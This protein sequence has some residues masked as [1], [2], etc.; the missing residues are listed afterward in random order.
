MQRIITGVNSHRKI[1]EILQSIGSKKFMLVCDGAFDF[2]PIKDYFAG[3][4]MPHIKFSD[5]SVNPLYE[6]VV[7][8]VELL[9]SSDCDAIVAVGGG[10]SIDVAKCIKL[11]AKM[12]PGENY[13][14]Q[15]FFDSEIP[16]I[17]LPTT[18]GTGSESTRYAVIYYGEQKQSVTHD[19]IVPNYAILDSAVLK[20]L[21]LYQRKCTLLD[22][23][24]QGIESWWSVNSTEESFG[25]SEMAVKTIIKNYL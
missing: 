4:F 2:L 7:K 11:F 22:A 9:R 1:G 12:T 17:A 13:L 14:K 5:F 19:S 21:P 6:D 10:S 15:T 23:L 20:T 3:I 8:G 16:L 24:C 18:A 25:Y